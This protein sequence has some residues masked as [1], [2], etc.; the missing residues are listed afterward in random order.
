[1]FLSR[2]IVQKGERIIQDI[3][4]KRGLNLIIDETPT[5][6]KK[7]GNNVGKTTMVR[8]IDYCLGG[9][10]EKIYK[11]RETNTE[12]KEVKKFLQS[13]QVRIK[14][15]LEEA[16]DGQLHE[17]IRSYGE[18]S[19][20]NGEEKTENEFKQDLN[21]ILFR[22]DVSKPSSRELLGKFIRTEN[23][24]LDNIYKFLYPQTKRPKDVY[25]YI[26][27][28]L[29]GFQ[30]HKATIRKNDLNENIKKIIDRVKALSP[31][32]EGAL[33]QI[34]RALDTDINIFE[35]KLKNFE[36]SNSHKENLESLKEIRGEISQLSVN[37]SNID[38][39]I[40]L[41]N[42][43]LK[44]LEK[45]RSSIDPKLLHN[46]YDQANAY[47]ETLQ[48]SFEEALDFHNSMIRNKMNFVNK[49]LSSLIQNRNKMKERMDIFFE[50]ERKFLRELSSKGALDDLIKCNQELSSLKEKRGEKN[51]IL[52][53]KK[54]LEE[55]LNQYN[56]ELK[57]INNKM[58]EFKG[59]LDKE[60]ED[61]NTLYRKITKELY[62]EEY[63]FSCEIDRNSRYDFSLSTMHGTVGSGKK[64][65]QILAFD[66][67]YLNFLEKKEANICRFQINDRLEEVHLNQLKRAFEI[68]NNIDGQFIVPILRDRIEAL[69][70][71]YIQENKIITLS[72]EQKFFKL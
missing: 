28:Y 9:K 50:E 60:L 14:L 53:E 45:T 42:Q 39:Q 57:N 55:E 63:I 20:I 65:G 24:Q 17:I 12:N 72:Q 22:L 41:N 47:V 3:P 71:D 37:I 35:K 5:A 30:N 44:N 48:K 59:R 7:S 46:I 70:K 4:F 67:A 16:K 34:I 18:K 49:H 68:A 13:S 6:N 26:Y 2:L 32:K 43:T 15:F 58:L 23:Y 19:I 8:V 33:T 10:C 52:K 62:D 61:F 54:E 36:I 40:K 29:F 31:Y 25:E 38:I 56:E 64:K 11:D 21:Q 27:L 1:M 66:L 51:G 69:G